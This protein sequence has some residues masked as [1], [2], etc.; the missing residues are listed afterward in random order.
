MMQREAKIARRAGLAACALWLAWAALPAWA[1]WGVE[2]TYK[3][4]GDRP[5]QG[6]KGQ[7]FAKVTYWDTNDDTPNPLYGCGLNGS[8][9]DVHI[10]YKDSNTGN[11][12]FGERVVPGVAAM[13]TLGE[14]AAGYARAG[15]LNRE[16][17][18]LEGVE[19]GESPCFYLGYRRFDGIGN[20]SYPLPGASMTCIPPTIHPTVCDIREAQLELNH[21]LLR[22]EAVNGHSTTTTLTAVCNFDFP[23]RVM[24]ADR[25]SEVYFTAGR[26]FRSDLTVNGVPLGQGVVTTA[27]P[28]G[29]RLTLRSVLSGYDGRIGRFGGSKTI[30]LSLP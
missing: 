5:G 4:N 12:A 20:L 1:G 16:F 26:S 13:K 30:I 7:Y 24:S 15:W 17:A 27:T 10:G 11:K 18:S 21:G 9:C 6:Y 28:Y 2:V 22:A 14:V 25:S 29:T 3:P 8:Y 23:V 19:P